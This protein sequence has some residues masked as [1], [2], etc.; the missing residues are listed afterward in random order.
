MKKKFPP[1]KYPNKTNEI[2]LDIIPTT[3]PKMKDQI[4]IKKEIYREVKKVDF[5]PQNL[6]ILSRNEIRQVPIKKHHVLQPLKINLKDQNHPHSID[7]LSVWKNHIPIEYLLSEANA[8]KLYPVS[9][10]LGLIIDQENWDA[11]MLRKGSTEGKGS[12]IFQYTY[13]KGEKTLILKRLKHQTQSIISNDYNIDNLDEEA[14]HFI[15]KCLV[16]YIEAMIF[17]TCQYGVKVYQLNFTFITPKNLIYSE[18]LMDDAGLDIEGALY[19]YEWLRND[20]DIIRIIQNIGEIAFILDSFKLLHNDIKPENISLFCDNKK[21]CFYLKLYD[22]DIGDIQS[23]TQKE[24]GAK[25]RFGFTKFFVA[26]EILIRNQSNNNIE[27]EQKNDLNEKELAFNPWSA[28]IYSFGMTILN[29]LSMCKKITN[30][31][32]K[33]SINFP[34]KFDK[35]F[36]KTEA[37]YLP[38]IDALEKQKTECKTNEFNN[39]YKVLKYCLYWDPQTRPDAVLLEQMLHNLNDKDGKIIEQLYGNFVISNLKGKE[40]LQDIGFKIDEIKISNCNKFTR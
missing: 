7:H 5:I 30:N 1:R 2:P 40:I 17:S 25:I 12:W 28:Q 29:I 13:N 9:A 33:S 24:I 14:K 34:I 36:K 4:E 38:F 31:E 6:A 26:P 32:L 39:I 15:R 23:Q 20:Q 21:N 8:I 11:R 22:F 37:D 19:H 16:E 35:K 10:S 3:D 18:L 27:I